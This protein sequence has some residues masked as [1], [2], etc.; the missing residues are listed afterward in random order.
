MNVLVKIIKMFCFIIIQVLFYTV[1]YFQRV[2]NC[3]RFLDILSYGL[4]YPIIN[5]AKI[6]MNFYLFIFL[7]SLLELKYVYMYVNGSH[8]DSKWEHVWFFFFF[9]WERSAYLL[10]SC[11]SLIF[12]INYHLT[13]MVI[14]L[15]RLRKIGL[16]YI[17]LSPSR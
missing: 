15:L 14:L 11:F 17:L 6:I 3:L 2:P 9:A 12:Y 5:W 13:Y 4:S 8:F 7:I 16:I 1:H 10:S